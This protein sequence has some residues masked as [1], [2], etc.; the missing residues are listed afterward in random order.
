MCCWVV[1]YLSSVFYPGTRQTT[2]LPSVTE[3]TLGK[4]TMHGKVQEKHAGNNQNWQTRKKAHGKGT[5]QTSKNTHDKET[6]M[7]KSRGTCRWQPRLAVPWRRWLFA[8]SPIM[9]TRE[10]FAKFHVFSSR[11]VAHYAPIVFQVSSWSRSA[12]KPSSF[13]PVLPAGRKISAHCLPKCQVFC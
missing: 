13:P 8:E 9:D 11:T 1:G 7:V 10:R 2:A 5:Q 12:N 3:K 4:Q 6:N